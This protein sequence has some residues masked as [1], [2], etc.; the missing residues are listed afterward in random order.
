MTLRRTLASV[1]PSETLGASAGKLAVDE[2]T[3]ANL[4]PFSGTPTMTVGGDSS[5]EIAVDDFRVD[6]FSVAP[7]GSGAP[8]VF[9]AVVVGNR[10][11]FGLSTLSTLAALRTTSF[12]RDFSCSFVALV[13]KGG[14]VGGVTSV[15]SCAAIWAC[16]VSWVDADFPA[17]SRQARKRTAAT[18]SIRTAAPV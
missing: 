4:S 5:P 12:G 11:G 14:I 7:S 2:I 1:T 18:R 3:L 17:G 13:A 15:T 8:S 6:D 9:L 16:V 10:S